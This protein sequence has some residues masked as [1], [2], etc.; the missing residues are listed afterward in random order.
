MIRLD[1]YLADMSIGTRNEVK[2]AIKAGNVSV[3]GHLALKPDI[4]IDENED[5]VTVN[6]DVI[7]YCKYEY[8]MLNK[9]MGYVS[10]TN[11]NL[12]STV[13]SLIGDNK[14][15]D[16]FPA[17]R[18]DIDTEGLLII[19]NDGELAHNLLAPKKHVNKTYFVITNGSP[20]E[21]AIDLLENGVDI[22]D[23]TLTLKAK[24][25][26]IKS[27][28]WSE[29]GEYQE[30]IKTDSTRHNDAYC[31]LE[32]KIHEG[33]YHQVKRMFLAI[34]LKVLYLKRIGMGQLKL[35]EKLKC[36]EYRKLTNE[37]ICFLTNEG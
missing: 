24:V 12:N 37:E 17:G 2:K 32:I 3:N 27:C 4:K 21:T 16:I 33:R 23:D 14:R 11:D 1:K 30:K 31:M 36:G 7:K 13:V 20:D 5:L 29:L 35:D 18:L 25:N 9:P 34:G 6:G 28:S 15:K 19:T 10:A 26:I 22:G 8:F